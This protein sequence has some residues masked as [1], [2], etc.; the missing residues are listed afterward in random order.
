MQSIELFAG[1]GGLALG[2]SKSGF[3]H[4]LI[5]EAD[6][7]A[8]ATLTANRHRIASSRNATI[9]EGDVREIGYA[10][11]AGSIDLV[12]GGPPCQPFSIGGKH[13]GPG[14]KRNMWPEAIRCIREVRPK[15]FVF[16]NVRG[17]LRPAFSKYLD[18]LRLQLSWPNSRQ[19]KNETSHQYL[20]RL[21]KREKDTTPSYRVLIH[22]I[23]AADYGAPQKRHRALIMGVRSDLTDK[24]SFPEKP[25]SKEALLWDQYVT[26]EYW[27]K[28]EVNRK[29]R[30]PISSRDSKLVATLK[31]DNIKPRSNSWVT[32]R[33]TIADLPNPTIKNSS[34]SL[35]TL[36]PGA[37]I[38][39][40]HT[41]STWDEP[42]KALK[43]GDHGVPGG[44]NVLVLKSDKVRYFTIREMARLQ[45]L[46]DD[47][48][49]S[50]AW[51][52]SIKQLGNAV[53]VQV[54]SFFGNEIR[55]IIS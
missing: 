47:Y 43:A 13:K 53:P 39:A 27:E 45:G 10:Q 3:Q 49:I 4:R 5:V 31:A 12:S 1:C 9:I 16:E 24:V 21:K 19:G 38:Y 30:A 26:E 14:D 52:S 48:Q 20:K 50:G 37:R 51:V 42:A 25:F 44:E 36:H 11:Y 29:N 7:N 6:A 54:G 8:C 17:L 33:D 40:G 41:G 22:D 15:A 34:N 55:R 46:P 35:H 2:I 32:V 28:H 23:N 18:L